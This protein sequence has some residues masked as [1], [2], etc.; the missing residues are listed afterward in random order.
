MIYPV[1]DFHQHSIN[2]IWLLAFILPV[3][4][5][6]IC[7]DSYGKA[8]MPLQDTT[9]R[10][11]GKVSNFEDG[12]PLAGASVENLRASVEPLQMRPEYFL[13]KSK[14]AIVFVFL[15]QEE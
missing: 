1:S 7:S 10:I 15:L 4:L 2:K 5:L 11:T 8:G 3:V 13:S 6:F 9:V 12:T 14:P